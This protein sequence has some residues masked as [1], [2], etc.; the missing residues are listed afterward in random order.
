MAT[1]DEIEC[2]ALA[3]REASKKRG[4]DG[5]ILSG[6]DFWNNMARAAIAAVRNPN[7][8]N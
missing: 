3:I 8:Q 1:I 5:K 2:V 6:D 7:N 4:K